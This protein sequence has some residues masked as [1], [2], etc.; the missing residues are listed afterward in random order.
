MDLSEFNTNIFIKNDKIKS[1][2]NYID[3]I[4]IQ[5]LDLQTQTEISNLID[6]L[7]AYIDNANTFVTNTNTNLINQDNLHTEK[8][9]LVGTIIKY[10]DEK[11]YVVLINDKYQ[12]N[13]ITIVPIEQR[14]KSFQGIFEFDSVNLPIGSK[15]LVKTTWTKYKC[16]YKQNTIIHLA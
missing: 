1:I 8:Y 13:K 15:V 9:E 5:Q 6:K 3:L 11:S 12:I 7:S 16:L 14:S 4:D 2:L 10:L